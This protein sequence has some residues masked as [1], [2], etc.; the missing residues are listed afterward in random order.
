MVQTNEAGEPILYREREGAIFIARMNRPERLNA[1]GGGLPEALTEAW[2]EFKDDPSLIPNAIEE[3]LRFDSSVQMTGR[4]TNAPVELGGV[5]IPANENSATF[6]ITAV[7]DTL[8]DGTQV[9]HPGKLRVCR[10]DVSR[11]WSRLG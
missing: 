1:L 4:V 9:V 11:R 2:F 5:T 6:S 3:L 8:L 7:D 10:T